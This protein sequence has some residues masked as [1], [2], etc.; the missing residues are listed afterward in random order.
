MKTTLLPALMCFVLTTQA[1]IKAT[2]SFQVIGEVNSPFTISIG[3]LKNFKEVVIGDFVVTNYLEFTHEKVFC[4]QC[5][6]LI[7][8]IIWLQQKQNPCAKHDAAKWCY[9]LYW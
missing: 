8:I 5:D 2:T 1:Q 7:I 6:H 4:Y 9:N 3:D